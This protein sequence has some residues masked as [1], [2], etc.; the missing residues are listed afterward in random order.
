MQQNDFFETKE[1]QMLHPLKQKII[2]ELATNNTNKSI[3]AIV[4]KIMTINKE[5]NKRNLSF[6]KAESKLMINILTKDM[7]PAEK[8]KIEM[9]MSMI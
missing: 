8:Q 6:T 9:I 5:L 4:P 2:M 3:E 1:F 7:S